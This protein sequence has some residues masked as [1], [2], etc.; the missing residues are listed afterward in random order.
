MLKLY[1]GMIVST[2]TNCI[3]D[4]FTRGRNGKIYICFVHL[5]KEGSLKSGRNEINIFCSF[6]TTTLMPNNSVINK[7]KFIC[8]KLRRV[9]FF[10]K[11]K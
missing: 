10:M 5:P 9:S 4:I 7:V 3:P 2:I 8:V 1:K 11:T 6:T